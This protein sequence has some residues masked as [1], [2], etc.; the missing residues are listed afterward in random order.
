MNK[1][2]T[3][4]F[5]KQ[6]KDS[7]VTLVIAKLLLK[8]VVSKKLFQKSEFRNTNLVKTIASLIRS[9]NYQWIIISIVLY[10]KENILTIIKVNTNIIKKL[11]YLI[12]QR[13]I[14]LREVYKNQKLT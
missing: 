1:N 8:I 5:L 14:M 4:V 10:V 9:L 6:P 2:L 3:K 13:Y 7:N 12:K 11:R